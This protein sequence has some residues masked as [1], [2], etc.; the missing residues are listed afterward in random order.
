MKT[1]ASHNNEIPSMSKKQEYLLSE[2]I[3]PCMTLRGQKLH[4]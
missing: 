3:T 4:P 2:V 1:Y